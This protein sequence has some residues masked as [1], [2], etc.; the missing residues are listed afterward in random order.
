MALGDIITIE[1][2]VVYIGRFTDT[3]PVRTDIS[4]AV[5]QAQLSI[6]HRRVEVPHTF[7]TISGVRTV[8]SKKFSWSV[9]LDVVTDGYGA[10][11]LDG[12]M[13]NLMP[14]PLG[15]STDGGRADIEIRYDDGAISASNP[16]YKGQI[17]IDQWNPLGSGTPGDIVRNSFTFMGDGDL[18]KDITP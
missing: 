5:A 9:T 11:E 7:G 2:A 12:I 10:A 14:A 15:S 13:T 3:P 18:E 16:A 1:D 8:A 6:V 4:Q 17:V